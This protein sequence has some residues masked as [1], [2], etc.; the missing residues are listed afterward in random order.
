MTADELHAL[1]V[2]TRDSA[3]LAERHGPFAHGYRRAARE[4]CERMG[5]MAE[6]L[7][8]AEERAR[9]ADLDAQALGE[10]CRSCA[11][12]DEQL[13]E[14]KRESGRLRRR[15][16]SEGDPARASG[17]QGMGDAVSPTDVTW[18]RL[19]HL[20]QLLESAADDVTTGVRERRG[21]RVSIGLLLIVSSLPE[22]LR[23]LVRLDQ[24]TE[25]AQGPG[26][27]KIDGIRAARSR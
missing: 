3:R 27:E 16:A 5:E 8:E 9:E 14:M 12:L 7:A 20:A 4:A 18:T 10:D 26:V 22:A 1:A 13:A 11:G 15:P 19:G 24:A 21:Y 2:R 23:L 25:D 17:A 6:Q